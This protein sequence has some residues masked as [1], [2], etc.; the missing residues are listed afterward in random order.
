MR[1][2]AESP[3]VA[4]YVYLGSAVLAAIGWYTCSNRDRT[5]ELVSIHVKLKPGVALDAA[6]LFHDAISFDDGDPR[7]R[8]EE[9]EVPRED[10]AATVAEL[11][12]DDR[13]EE[14]FVAPDISLPSGPRTAA[15]DSCPITT[16]SFESYQE[17]VGPAPRGIDAPAAWQRNARGAGVWF[18]DVEGNWNADHEDLP[19]DRMQHVGGIRFRD[20]S[21]RAHG[22]AVLG[23][24]VGRDNGKGVVGLAP[25]VEHVV[26]SSI[27]GTSVA[28]AIDTAAEALRPGDVL[29]VELQGVGPR[30]RYVPVEYWD[31]NF[32]AIRAATER[33]IVVI[34]AAGNGGEDLDRAVYDRKFDRW[35]RDSGAILVG[36]GGPPR[37]GY[38]DRVRLDFSNY[39]QRV[40]VQG[41]GRKVATLDY[42]DLQRC[43]GA[44]RH[45]TGEFSGT[46]SASP[47]V[48]GAAILLQS[49]ARAHGKR[50]APADV[51]QLLRA[52]GTPQVGGDDEQIGPRPDLARALPLLD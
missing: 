11:Q 47:M 37:D 8:W 44:D 26:T 49:Y 23:E 21:W 14:A 4:R 25:D 2:L 9:V 19:G 43:S 3:R 33:G 16:P 30:G 7:W 18:A 5:S 42:G 52:T 10:A 39:G 38:S 20:P 22:T 15:D 35:H 13:V 40:D 28:D 24:V 48:A 34:E 45:Y 32:D 51:R 1:R 6:P 31:D 50:L 27:G 17:Y 41:W 36:A 12:R 46:S 29:L